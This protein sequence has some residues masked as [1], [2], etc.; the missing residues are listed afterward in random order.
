MKIAGQT[1]P[2]ES[3]RGHVTGEALYTDDLAARFPASAARL[4]G[5]GA[6][7]ARV[8]S[9]VD[10]SAALDEP[11]VVTML[12]AADV[13]GE[14]DS[15]VEPA[16]RAAVSRPVMFHP[17]PVAWVL[18]ET[19][20]AA[21][22]GAARVQVG[23][24]A[25]ARDPARSK[26]PSRPES[27]SPARCDLQRGDALGAIAVSPRHLAAKLASAARNISIWK[28]SAPSR[29]STKRAAV[30]WSPPRSIPAETQDDR[31]ARSWAS[32]RIRSRSNAC[33]WA[34]RSAARK[35]RPIPGRRS[36]R[37]VRGRRGGR[38]ACACRARSTWRSPASGIRSWRASTP[39]FDDDG[40][41]RGRARSRSIPTAAGVS[42][43]PSRC[44]GA[45]MFH[46]DNAYLLPAV[47][48]TGYVCRTHK[49]SQTAFRGFGGPQGMLV[50]EDILDRIAR[51]LSACRPK[52]CASA[53]SIAKA[54]PRTTASR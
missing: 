15:G 11:G 14:G 39:G 43:F 46:V 8:R 36:R 24:R 35:C 29:G 52:W 27:S 54:T 42:I 23:I 33:A 10:A 49:T 47:D 40:R 37:S 16:R 19:L 4:A 20:E 45:R 26:T 6:A 34:E 1:L 21:R 9:N 31:G 5:A 7:C 44:S 32:P 30:P 13:P 41:L 28:R 25:A 18:G 38:C 17:Q 22:A 53:I 48:V 50:I 51:T 3:A 12:T 2:H